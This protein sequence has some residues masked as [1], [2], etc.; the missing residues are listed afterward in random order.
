MKTEH[1][2]FKNDFQTPINVARYMVSLIPNE[3]RTVLEPTPGLGTLVKLLKE[4]NVTAPE[5]YFLLE[6]Q[7]WDTII[8]NPPF[9]LKYTNIENAPLE[10]INKGMKMGYQIL[11]ECMQMTDNVIALMPWFT[12]SDSDI[13]LK[14]LKKYGLKSLTALPRK[15]F[16]Y[17]RVQTVIIELVRGYKKDTSFKVFDLLNSGLEYTEPELFSNH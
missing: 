7:R 9:A 8:M 6:K 10:R 13:R 15:T 5:D 11:F 2:N 4:Y 12:I 17:A 1:E 3:S 14:S 16:Q